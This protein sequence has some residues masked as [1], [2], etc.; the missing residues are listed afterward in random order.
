MAAIAARSPS[1]RM[2]ESQALSE[3]VAQMEADGIRR[4]HPTYSDREVFLAQVRHR[5]GDE[6]FQQAWTGEPL[7]AP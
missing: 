1:E 3:A 2:A 6:L 5:Y 7:L 4:R